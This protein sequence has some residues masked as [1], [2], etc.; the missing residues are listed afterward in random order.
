MGVSELF[1]PGLMESIGISYG[2]NAG[3]GVSL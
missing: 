1:S 3:K 2:N